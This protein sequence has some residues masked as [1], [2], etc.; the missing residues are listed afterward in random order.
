MRTPRNRKQIHRRRSKIDKRSWRLWGIASM[1]IAL[2]I[3][4]GVR[5]V[6]VQAVQH[7]SYRRQA[8]IQQQRL[9]TEKAKRGSIFDRRGMELALDVQAVSFYADPYEVKDITGIVQHFSQFGGSNADNLKKRLQSKRRFVYLAR[10]LRDAELLEAQAVDFAGVYEHFETRR[11]YPYSAV[12]GQLL[13]FVDID[14]KGREGVERGFDTSM[15][16]TDG[17][18]L[19]HVDSRGRR[20]PGRELAYTPPLNGNELVLT[21]DIIY[22]DILEEEL[23]RAVELS[24]AER[25]LGIIADPR[26][27]EILAMGNVP[28][29]DPNMAG[30]ARPGE[31][32]NRVITDPFEPGSTFKMIT[33]AA[34]LEEGLVDVDEEVFCENGLFTLNNG[35]LIRDVHPYGKLNFAQV[36][37][38]SSNIGVIKM[39]RRL[40]RGKFYQYIRS[41]GF[42]IRSGVGLPAESAGLLRPANQWSKRSLETLAIGQEISV[43]ALQMVQALGVI[44]NEGILMAPKLV[45]EIR[46]AEGRTVEQQPPKP[47]RRVISVETASVVKNIL[48]G[49][50][51][52][53]TGKRAAITGV[54]IAGK[55][56]TAQRVASQGKGYADGQYVVSFMGFLPVDAPRLMGVVVVDNPRKQKYGGEV[57][58][59]AFKKIME[60]IL[61]AESN[62]L[63]KAVRTD[64][65]MLRTGEIPDLRGL[66]AEVARFQGEVR[67]LKVEFSG[68]GDVVV[69]QQPA[70]GTEGSD[71]KQIVCKLG[72]VSSVQA[73]G[74][75]GIPLR[76]AL[77]LDQLDDLRKKEKKDLNQ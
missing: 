75:H 45:K 29:Y 5:L 19:S 51:E 36:I 57:A 68:R 14:N 1:L 32:R 47:V 73:V 33:A 61:S 62:L 64:S 53:G 7:D 54:Q 28:L 67:G 52:Q 11:Y 16:G 66:R 30:Q 20:V 56:G 2:W 15:Q 70:V 59:P 9:T 74:N 63:A 24:G 58:A 8:Q 43:T 3:F 40:E 12:G 39:A 60:R 41:F 71:V 48:H 35:D 65:S 69:S 50:V 55:T 4:V 38:K 17:H 31:R 25:A 22:Q 23:V 34:V 76:Q 10:G 37:E 46:N 49:V 27:G 26:T 13:G 72:Y 6:Q 77:F 42:G 44:A 21:I 18:L